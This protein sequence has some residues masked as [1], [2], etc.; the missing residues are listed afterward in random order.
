MITMITFDNEYGHLSKGRKT[1][2]EA[3]ISDLHFGSM[4]QIKDQYQILKEQFIE[5]LKQLPVL[6]IVSINGDIF[7][8]KA[9]GNS[10]ML[11]YALN[12]FNDLIMEVIRPKQTTLVIIEGT[13]S[14][15]SKQLKL[16]YQHLSDPTIDV[17]IVQ[18]IQFEYIKGA[19]IL[20]IPDLASITEETYNHYLFESGIYDSVFMHGTI[21]GAIHGDNVGNCRLFT[22]EDFVL[23]TG[24]IISGHV[25]TGGCFN[26]YFYYCGSPY[27][28]QFGEEGDKGFLI[29]LHNLNTQEH[30]VYKEIIQSFRY[31]TMNLDNILE[32]DP[33]EI[34]QYI[35]EVKVRDNIDF[36]RIEFNREVPPDK[37]SIIDSFYRNNK[38]VKF[39]Y[40]FTKDHK[41][42][43]ENLYEMEDMQRY[44]YIYDKTL[45]EY[46]ILARYVNESMD[47]IYV[48]A[49]QI[50]KII[51]EEM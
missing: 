49:D 38:T 44:S 33:R 18:N 6:D 26:T 17:R 16:F 10:D 3:H 50:K 37:K 22:I 25:H 5:P 41:R 4:D 39:K 13:D 23:C 40:N 45:S 20:C 15:D 19:K 12:F 28:W 43:E 21:K 1:L 30:Y 51:E 31:I 11:M 42:I 29:L 14:H 34:I 32:S 35:D 9:M 36:I 7:H 2:I 48:S 47:K 27:T 46:D 24:P 8:H